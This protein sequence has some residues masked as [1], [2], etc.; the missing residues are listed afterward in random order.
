MQQL[1]ILLVTL[2]VFFVS[3]LGQAQGRLIISEF[4]A[5]NDKGLKDSN[6][7]RSDWIEIH[8]AGDATIDL[9]GWA[10]TDDAKDEVSAIHDGRCV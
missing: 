8:N 2:L 1:Y 9:A 4:L 7:E 5:V 3:S 6:G 10:L